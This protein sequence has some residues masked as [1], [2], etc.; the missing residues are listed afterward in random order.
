MRTY[1][2]SDYDRR[3]KTLDEALA[4]PAYSTP[5]LYVGDGI[6]WLDKWKVALNMKIE[7][8]KGPDPPKWANDIFEAMRKEQQKN[9]Y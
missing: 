3:A 6:S 2:L 1:D 7:L 4:D 9:N 8:D 5:D